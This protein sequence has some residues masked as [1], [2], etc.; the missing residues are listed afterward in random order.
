M[1]YRSILCTVI[2]SPISTHQVFSDHQRASSR[3][4]NEV[5]DRCGWY[6]LGDLDDPRMKKQAAREAAC[7]VGSV[8]NRQPTWATRFWP[9]AS[10]AVVGCAGN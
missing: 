5:F 6:L 3:F 1:S 4:R 2:V 8:P 10:A 9:S 7:M